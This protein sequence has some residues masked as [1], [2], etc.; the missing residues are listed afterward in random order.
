MTQATD[1]KDVK[2]DL[3]KIVELFG[4][5]KARKDLADTKI[6]VKKLRK[7][8]SMRQKIG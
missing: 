8:M 6:W 4:S 3:N 5:W 7:I 2:S 1:G